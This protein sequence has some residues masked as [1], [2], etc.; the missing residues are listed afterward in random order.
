MNTKTATGDI[1]VSTRGSWAANLAAAIREIASGKEI[2][3]DTYTKR[4]LA[5]RAIQRMRPDDNI[6]VTIQM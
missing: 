4:E 5:L 6:T 3:V 1:F 2:V